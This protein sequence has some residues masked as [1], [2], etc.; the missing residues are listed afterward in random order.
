MTSST[1]NVLEG[2][3]WSLLFGEFFEQAVKSLILAAEAGAER[4]VCG[5]R[6]P[7]V[8]GEV[9]C[10]VLGVPEQLS[11]EVAVVTAEQQCP[12]PGGAVGTLELALPD[13]PRTGTARV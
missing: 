3:E 6:D 8:Q 7:A 4:F 11:A 5:A 13:L 1:S 2:A 9:L 12:L 10:G